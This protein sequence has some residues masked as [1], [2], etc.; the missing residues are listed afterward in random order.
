MPSSATYRILWAPCP[1]ESEV[2]RRVGTDRDIWLPCLVERVSVLLEEARRLVAD[3]YL[4]GELRELEGQ[5]G[6]LDPRG[7]DLFE[8]E[9]SPPAGQGS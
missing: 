7:W 6:P 3:P 5:V 4:L 2:G 8:T 1:R 9:A